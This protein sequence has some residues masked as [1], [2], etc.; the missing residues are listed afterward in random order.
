MPNSHIGGISWVLMGLIRRCTVVLSADP[1]PGNLLNLMRSHRAEYSFIV[2]T[3]IRGLV[4]E[5]RAG[6]AGQPVRLRGMFYGAMPM[7]E[8]LLH[9]AM[10]VFAC[11][12][13]QFFGMTEVAGAATRLPPGDHDP[14]RPGLLKSVGKPYPGMSIEI[15]GPDRRLLRSGEH[16]EV[17]IKSPTAMQGYRNLPDKTGEAIIDGWYA[18]GDGGYLDADGYLYLT[19]RIRD[20]I[21][22]GG[23]NV[24]PAEVE[25]ALRHHPAVLD[26]AVVGMPDER[27]G[28]LIAAAV[29]LRPGATATAQELQDV[30]RE[31]I[32]AF[33]SPKLIRFFA[34]LPRTAAGKVQRGEIRKLL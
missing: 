17:W 14:A 1:S 4:D 12:F 30:A 6:N 2:P 11:P 29:E 13:L 8:Q 16:G 3:V 26:A 20:M 22:S 10:A 33:K 19:D 27:W 24:Y 31:Y 23:E 15:R 7:S 18:T 28:E 34:Q 32:A 25:E 21:V 5:L 9:A